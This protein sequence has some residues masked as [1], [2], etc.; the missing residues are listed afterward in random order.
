MQSLVE[1]SAGVSVSMCVLAQQRRKLLDMLMQKLKAL[2]QRRPGH[3]MQNHLGSS[4]LS[5]VLTGQA[6]ER[7][8]W[9]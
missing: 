2:A 5:P 4:V 8:V 9:V 7:Q 3:G 6:S 1:A